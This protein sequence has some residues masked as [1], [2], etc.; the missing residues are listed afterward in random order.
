MFTKLSLFSLLAAGVL[1]ILSGCSG[2]PNESGLPSVRIEGAA[3]VSISPEHSPGV[4]DLFSAPLDIEL[5]DGTELYS[6]TVAVEAN[7]KLIYSQSYSIEDIET[8]TA[9]P[10]TPPVPE[11]V[12]WLGLNND[13]EPVEEGRYRLTVEIVDSFD[14]RATSPAVLIEVDNTPP[15]ASVKLSRKLFSPDDDGNLDTIGIEQE[16]SGAELWNGYIVRQTRGQRIRDFAWRDKLPETLSWDGE[17]LR[18]NRA[19]PGNYGY[20]LVARDKAGNRTIVET[21]SFRLDLAVSALELDVSP[22]PFTPDDD[23]RND[24]V[25]IAIEASDPTSIAGWELAIYDPTGKLFREFSGEGNPEEPIVWDGR[26][27]DGER[28]QAASDYQAEAQVR[29][30]AGNSSAVSAPIPVGILVDSEEDGS[31]RIRISSIHFVPFE[32]DFRNLE[33]PERVEQNK[34]VLDELSRML[35]DYK[36]YKVLIEGHAAHLTR[37]EEERKA[38]QQEILLPLS[39]KRAGAIRDAL[40]KRGIDGERFT[41]AGRGGNEPVVPHTDEEERWKNRRVEFELIRR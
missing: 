12:E 23:G 21:E 9:N 14:R 7:E 27:S 1:L 5:S 34:E 24:T 31:L 4:K 35:K 26:N 8:L 16:S 3:Q 6:Y 11:R 40:Q 33:D 39:R 20:T 18:G 41:T 25:S 13:L 32:A 19:A 22:R 29:D 10:P 28:V 15:E 37:G 36:D 30:Q 38:E 17:T 2:V